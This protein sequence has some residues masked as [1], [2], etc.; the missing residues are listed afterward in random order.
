M[1]SLAKHHILKAEKLSIQAQNL[2]SEAE[3][4]EINISECQKLIKMAEELLDV[5]QGCFRGQNY[6]AAYIYALKAIEI[7]EE[8][9]ELLKELLVYI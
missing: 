8:S 5:A 3:A 7:Y 9:I 1:F 4:K 2:L 6:I